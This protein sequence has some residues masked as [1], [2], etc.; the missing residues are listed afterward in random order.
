MVQAIASQVK[1]NAHNQTLWEWL[2]VLRQV[3]AILEERKWAGVDVSL[4]QSKIS[5]IMSGQNPQKDKTITIRYLKDIGPDLYAVLPKVLRDDTEVIQAA[6]QAWLSLSSIPSNLQSQKD[7]ITLSFDTLIKKWWSLLVLIDFIEKYTNTSSKDSIKIKYKLKEKLRVILQKKKIT[8]DYEN[9][10]AYLYLDN[11]N[12]YKK[13]ISLGIFDIQEG[14]V[15]LN[16]WFSKKI[17]DWEKWEQDIDTELTIAVERFFEQHFKESNTYLSTIQDMIITQLIRTQ[18]TQEIDKWETEEDTTTQTRSDET[19]EVEDIPQANKATTF[20]YY[21]YTIHWDYYSFQSQCE[22]SIDIPRRFAESMSET[23]IEN[24]VRFSKLMRDLWLD[25]LLSKHLSKVMIATEINFFNETGMTESKTL[26]FLNS[27][28]KNLWIPEKSY[29]DPD[30]KE[31]RVW[32][33]NTLTAAKLQFQ[34]VKSTGYL[35]SEYIVS[36]WNASGKSIVEIAFKIKW[37]ITG[38]YDEISLSKWKK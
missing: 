24:Y 31:I 7:Y 11:I 3:E 35:W 27:I 9:T 13:L 29:Q 36:P 6:L 16:S 15:L 14:K 8:Y 1:Y 32:C 5:E 10:L 22:A 23:S 38:P 2:D 21:H 30:S 12:I 26:S 20:S 37:L 34:E 4:I 33:F 25:F 28:G 18:K 19:S 17:L